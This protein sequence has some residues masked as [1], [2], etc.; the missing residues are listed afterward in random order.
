MICFAKPGLTGLAYG[1]K[2]RNFSNMLLQKAK[3]IHKILTHHLVR[4]DVT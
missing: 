1:A 2:D 3:H 4:E